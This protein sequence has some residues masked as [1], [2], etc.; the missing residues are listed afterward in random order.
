[1][2]LPENTIL[3]NRYR[4]DGLIRHGGNG[5]IYRALDLTTGTP[6]AIKENFF[7]SPRRIVQFK[8]EAGVL[9]QL[10]HPLLPTVTHYFSF[11]GEQYLV[12]DYIE[13][14][15]LW[16]LV[17]RRGEPL[18]EAEAVHYFLQVC[19][20]VGYLHQLNPPYIHRDIKPRNVIINARGQAIL[21]DFGIAKQV[22]D[23]DSYAQAGPQGVV[24]K[25]ASPEQYSGVGIRPASDI[26]SLG[27]T[28]YAVLT[29]EVP[30][31]CVSRLVG[32]SKLN[33]PDTVNS[34]LSPETSQAIV[35]A[36]AL[37]PEGRP[38]SVVDWAESLKAIAE[39]LPSFRQAIDTVPAASIAHKESKVLVQAA[40]A[41]PATTFWLVDST[42]VGYPLGPEPLTIGSEPATDVV[43]PDA[44]VAPYHTRVRVDQ[45]YCYVLDLG[46]A[47]GTYLNGH[48]L[49]A[50]WY[51]LNQGDILIVGYARFY[52]TAT[53]PTRLVP[54]KAVEAQEGMTPLPAPYT[55]GEAH[56]TASASPKMLKFMSGL[57]LV[58]LLLV[59]AFLGLW[60]YIQPDPELLASLPTSVFDQNSWLGGDGQ[61]AADLVPARTQE[62][63]GWL[64]AQAEYDTTATSRARNAAQT[65]QAV[66]EVTRQS[67]PKETPTAELI[68]LPTD[69]P[70]P[71]L[72]PV[73]PTAT[74]TPTAATTPTPAVVVQAT[75][76]PV[77]PT[78]IPL[79]SKETIDR[80]GTQQVIDVDINP[81]NPREVYALVKG[82]GIY[83]STTGGDGPW[84]RMNLDGSAITGLVI[85]P[86]TPTHMYAGTWNAV[87]KSADGGSSWDPKTEGLVA[88]QVVDIVVVHPANPDTLYASIGETL[89]VSTDGGESWTSL[90]Y[91]EGLGLERIY[92]IVVDPFE[93][94]TIYVGGLAAAIYK[95]QDSGKSFVQLGYNVGKG[96][97][98]M[99]AHPKRKDVYVA[100]INSGAAGIIKTEDGSE[101]R[102]TSTGLIYGG[103]DSS[104]SAIAYAPTNPEIIYAGSGYESNP[105]SKGIFKST[106]G[107]ETWYGAINGLNINR[108]T[109]FPYYVKSMAVHP[110]NP[111]I[112][113]AATGSGLYKS[114]DGGVSWELR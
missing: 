98:G 38:Q 112:V 106:D 100:G 70:A 35:A 65:R 41:I 57:A 52:L 48:R 110:T 28:L 66:L 39:S 63:A 111:N 67:Q 96:I 64:T 44:N 94:N 81:K 24:P 102:S 26:Y 14:E 77:G 3:E 23:E 68:V 34:K 40:P 107:G 88:N 2:T 4:I 11:E 85:D 20:A 69:T 86:N 76:V 79:Q 83:K 21:V 47:E 59:L 25:F 12:M 46:S 93:V 30:P 15:N 33:L 13:G 32:D 37:K 80:L 51:P 89:V 61:T 82:D 16:E 18:A 109:G 71:T 58:L 108:D 8:Q 53:E 7:Q 105:D 60:S 27:A 62:A 114:V 54:P 42:G 9:V 103:G 22:S 74:L 45:G 49:P 75:S 50:E 17:N 29:G 73:T 95:S 92:S 91:G 56:S 90:G 1:M 87:L 10:Y 19:Q 99:A 113:F 72:P 84:H 104:Y 5:A 43:I 101:F 31:N 97:F 78:L 36:M 55:V 6:V